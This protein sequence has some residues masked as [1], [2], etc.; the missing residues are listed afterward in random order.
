MNRSDLVAFYAPRL[1]SMS[2]PALGMDQ[3][4]NVLYANRTLREMGNTPSGALAP[5]T[6]SRP[7]RLRR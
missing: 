4:G 1:E 2:D 7:E 6:R 3:G 5:G